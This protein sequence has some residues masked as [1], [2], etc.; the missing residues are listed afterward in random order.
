MLGRI[1]KNN[2]NGQI[3][4]LA[5]LKP[6]TSNDLMALAYGRIR[7]VRGPGSGSNGFPMVGGTTG[8]KTKHIQ[9]IGSDVTGRLRE[10]HGALEVLWPIAFWPHGNYIHT[11]SFF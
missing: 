7:A 6:S 10:N 2:P 5:G 1:D 9:C 4:F 8:F 11:S 3:F